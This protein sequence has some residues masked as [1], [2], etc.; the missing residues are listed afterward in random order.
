MSCYAAASVTQH[1]PVSA[2]LGDAWL[3]DPAHVGLCKPHAD[4]QYALVYSY[5]ACSGLQIIA[6]SLASAGIRQAVS[7]NSF[8]TG[9]DRSMQAKEQATAGELPISGR[10]EG[11]PSRVSMLCL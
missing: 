10:A 8:T 4:V 9:P 3:L 1:L 2:V 7:T 11:V 5:P 6:G